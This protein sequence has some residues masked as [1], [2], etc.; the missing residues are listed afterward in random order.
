[1]PFIDIKADVYK[2]KMKAIPEKKWEP[3]WCPLQKSNFPAQC[4]NLYNKIPCNQK[5]VSA[6]S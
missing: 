3:K 5:L 4:Q 1:M 6:L 2:S